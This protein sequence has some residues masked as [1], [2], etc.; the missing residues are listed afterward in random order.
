[1]ATLQ[2]Y[3]AAYPPASPPT[4]DVV[5]FYIGGDTPHVWTAAEI[6]RQRARYRLP[7]YVRSNPGSHNPHTDATLALRW[8][9]QNGAPRGCA[10]VLDLET[11]VDGPYVRAFDADIVAGGYVTVAYGSLSTIFG[12]PRTSGGY[13]VANPTG[14]P[15]MRS[16]AVATQWAFD[17]QLGKP[18]D[19]SDIADSV[20]L[21]DTH[22]QPQED[23]MPYGGQ[24]PAGKGSQINVS[25]PHGSMHAAG[26]VLDNSLALDGVIEAEP[27]AVIRYAFHRA[28]G[29]W[30]SGTVK[31]GS[32]NQGA[33][34]SPKA[35]VQLTNASDVDW[36]SFV[37]LDDGKRPVG[38]DMS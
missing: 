21:W 34:H 15:H 24:I 10:V 30:Q 26:F 23:N 5:A 14:T 1:M 16:G 13:W 11:A 27:Q 25:F 36:A 32:A 19:L 31:V 9:Q 18:W 33:D 20:P 12:N 6:A 29:S 7:I 28:A 37:R 22:A 3:D 35:V 8:L 38:W 4:T 17:T 2:M